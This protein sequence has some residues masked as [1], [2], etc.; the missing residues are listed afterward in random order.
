MLWPTDLLLRVTTI[1]AKS[2]KYY[3]ERVTE[4]TIA[5]CTSLITTMCLSF[6]SEVLAKTCCFPTN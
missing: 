6:T 4:G 3:F 1:A 2:V 5:L